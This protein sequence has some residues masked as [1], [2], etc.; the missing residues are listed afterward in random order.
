MN[1]TEL[2]HKLDR[3]VERFNTTE[4]IE[5]DP[6]LFPRRYQN[7]QDIEISAFLTATIAWGKRSLILKSAEKMHQIMGHS[8]YD[9]IMSKAYEKLSTANI[10]RTFFENDMAYLCR[11]LNAVYTR[12]DTCED[13][14]NRD[15]EE[16]IWNGIALLRKTIEDAN[17]PQNVKSLRHIS[18]PDSS[19]ACKRLNMALRWLIRKDHIVDI[20][21]WETISPS[22]LKIPLDVHVGNA[23]RR[24]GLLTR[25]QNDKK[26]V[27]ELT[28][29]L[30]KFN[31]ADPIIYDFALFG[32]EEAGVL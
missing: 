22:E 7:K 17:N 16:K 3:E 9:F 29:N 10:H 13:L 30:K 28:D 23:S 8:P 18:N 1:C 4:F 25:K 11:G 31:S 2:K 32:A 26:A 27:E 12:H 15:V 5:K 6:V 24:F 14:F 19:S 21:I 20:G